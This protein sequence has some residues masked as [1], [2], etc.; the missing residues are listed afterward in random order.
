[1]PFFDFPGPLLLVA[2]AIGVVQILFR[3]AAA[4][5]HDHSTL[6]FRYSF[7]GVCSR[8]IGAVREPGWLSM[9]GP[10]V[11]IPNFWALPPAFSGAK[12]GR[13]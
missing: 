3:H 7:A 4:R 13:R 8:F 12:R 1:M 5:G 10:C 6:G 11:A 9:L 2:L